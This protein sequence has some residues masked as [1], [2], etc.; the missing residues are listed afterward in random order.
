MKAR[1]TITKAVVNTIQMGDDISD[2]SYIISR[3]YTDNSITSA[4]IGEVKLFSNALDN[5]D[6]TNNYT[7]TLYEKENGKV[8]TNTNGYF[9]LSNGGTTFRIY[10]EAISKNSN[11]E[12]FKGYV[13]FKYGSVT[14][15]NNSNYMTIE[16]ALEKAVSGNTIY[17]KYNT[18]FAEANIAEE[19]YRTNTFEVKSGVTLLLPFD[20]KYSTDLNVKEATGT[21]VSRTGGYVKLVMPEDTILNITGTLT[22]NAKFGAAQPQSGFVTGDNY[23]QIE[24]KFNSLMN[25]NNGGII[26]SNGFIYG[27][28]SIEVHSGRKVYERL[29]I[30][31]FRG[32]TATNNIYNKVFPFDQYSFNNIE[33]RFNNQ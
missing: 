29:V 1:L 7:I 18:S 11:R 32:G 26:N 28:G 27:S 22:V 12:D 24:M 30:H 8:I 25:V 33:N 5:I 14:I 13:V 31:D 23:A 15:G 19:V 17:V 10:M 16:D 4:N 9:D 21:K 6:V 20:D 2:E 3:D